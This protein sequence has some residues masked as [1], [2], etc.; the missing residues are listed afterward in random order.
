MKEGML[1]AKN[2]IEP[3]ERVR[4][5]SSLNRAGV[6]DRELPVHM[7]AAMGRD[8]QWSPKEQNQGGNL[9]GHDPEVE[10]L[11]VPDFQGMSGQGANQSTMRPKGST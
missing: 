1:K 11:M 4:G 9:S 2:P 8:C 5:D 3:H 10:L 7:E 6:S